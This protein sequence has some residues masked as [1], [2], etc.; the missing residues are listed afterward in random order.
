VWRPVLLLARIGRPNLGQRQYHATHMPLDP[1]ASRFAPFAQADRKLLRDVHQPPNTTISID[2]N[3]DKALA[4][5][6]RS[7]NEDYD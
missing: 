7:L 5:F 1:F 4:A 3:E 6:L 2:D